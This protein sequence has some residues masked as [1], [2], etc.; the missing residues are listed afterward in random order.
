MDT[1]KIVQDI[2][3][4]FADPLPDYYN[5]R[6]IFWYDEEHEFKDKLDDIVLDNARLISLSNDNIY[7]IKKLLCADDLKSNFLVYTPIS[8]SKI[9]D[10]RLL[11]VQLYSEEFRADLYSIWIDEMHLPNNQNIREIVKHYQKFF[12][13]ASRRN[14]V[15]AHGADVSKISQLHL[16]VMA[17]I[18]GTKN[19]Q[20]ND[21]LKAV[22][23]EGLDNE[24]NKLYQ[25]IIQYDAEEAFWQMVS[26]GTG[27]Q[28]NDNKS[29]SELA[30]H[31]LLTATSRTLYN[32]HLDGLENHFSDIEKH[33]AWCYEFI[34]DWIHSSERR[35][36]YEVARH[37]ESEVRLEQRFLQISVK[38]LLETDIFPCINEC[39][40]KQLMSGICDEIIQVDLIRQVIEKRRTL[41]W[42]DEV[43]CYYDG[44]A[45]VANMREFYLGHADGFHIQDTEKL[46]NTYTDDYYRMDK[47]YRLY[48]L[49]FQKSLKTSN[50]HF[51]ELDDLF[52]QITDKMENL[53]TNWF[54]TEL[55]QNWLKACEDEMKM[56]GHV[57]G[58]TQQ[59]ELYNMARKDN[60]RVYVIIS[61]AFRY[62][63]ATTLTENLLQEMQCKV[64]L[65]SAEAI[66]PTATKFGMAALLPH[67]HL[68]AQVHSN[69]QLA[70]LADGQ[71]TEAGN[72][73]Q[74]LQ[75]RDK[76]SVALKYT[77]IIKMKRNERKELVKGMDVVYIYH[78]RID[79]ASHTSDSDVF[80][81][82]DEA[83]VEIKKMVSIIVNE[84]SGTHIFITADHG[85][86]Y[87]YNTLSEDAKLDKT[88]PSTQDVEVERRYLIT[89]K[90]AKAENLMPVQFLDGDTDF[91]AFAPKANVRIKKRGG[92][93]NFV[94]GGAS[95]Q[96]LVIPVIEY[97]HLRSDAAGYKRK[98]D[99]IDTTPVKLQLIGV[100]TKIC[101]MLFSLKLYQTEAVGG[102]RV[103]CNYLLHFEDENGKDV[104]DTQKIIADKTSDNELD[105]TFICNFHLRS[106][107]YDSKAPYYL[108]IADEEGLQLPIR[109]RFQIDI[110]FAVDDFDFFV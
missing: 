55:S 33:K 45:Q 29:L 99:E 98:R 46:W 9:D 39:I 83:I 90:G 81:A 37:V 109:E 11:I 18:C 2:N 60:S 1:D 30:E 94:H 19:N 80:P 92:G 106:Q 50:I 53:Y 4:R 84:F 23:C 10:Y 61:D 62:E 20:P 63:V 47:Y 101:N 40:L 52:K 54:L 44:L 12:N 103:P 34:T 13:A 69:G 104:S 48:H 93:L 87:T 73:T 38:D 32:E 5:R 71:S 49:S 86:L 76:N 3:Q 51:D 105:R 59:E 24:E 36:I 74:V 6:I 85:F 31:I 108:V 14:K 66:F 21:I 88:T 58:I 68:T 82:C 35:K 107:E 91:D 56:Y 26:Q 70:I 77:D 15:A 89:K 8:N 64:T 78:N 95:L 16:A 67:K 102:N 57:K 7:S 27:Y 41:A 110:A 72:R 96:E 75:S 42:Y 97:Q 17:A 79:E 25:D 28:S 22:L 100:T 65:K 43:S